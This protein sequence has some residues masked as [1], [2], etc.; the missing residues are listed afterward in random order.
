LLTLYGLGTTIGAGIYVIIG[1]TAGAAGYYMPLAFIIASI[2]AG[3]S[4]ASFAELSVR[5]PVSAGEAVYIEAGLGWRNLSFLAGLMIALS[6]AVSSAT[7]LQGGTGYLQ[8]LVPAPTHVLFIVLLVALAGLVAWGIA[9]SLTV[10]A[11]FT[12]F[13]VAGLL[14]IIA[15]APADPLTL[16]AQVIE[17]APAF[18]AAVVSGLSASL[19]LAFF[20]FIGFEDMVNVAEEVRE[21]HRNMPRAIFLTLAI[22]ALLY[23]WISLIALSVLTPADLAASQAP[24]SE[25]FQA[26]AGSGAWMLSMVAVTA[27]LNGIIIQLVMSSRILYGLSRM[28]HLP[29]FLGTVS[30]VTHTPIAATAAVC[31][32]IA[33][34]GMTLQLTSLATTTSSFTMAAFALVNLSLW[35]L[36]GKPGMGQPAFRVPRLVPALGFLASAGFLAYETLRKLSA[37]I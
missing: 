29:R 25:I 13:E 27:V 14:A 23:I 24:L 34:L 8:Q 3:L 15:F 1:A 16:A 35:R 20:A 6:G 9:Q 11:V 7:L 22:T 30:P 4:A 21:P 5:F 18:D 19:L 36:K 31:I 26:T 37:Y 10:A 2:I 33:V 17:K 12:V 28:G 32:V